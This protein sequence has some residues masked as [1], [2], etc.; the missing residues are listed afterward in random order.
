MTVNMGVLLGDVNADKVVNSADATV[1]RN[2]SGQNANATNFR[3][4]LNADGTIN[5]ADATIARN[6]SGQSLP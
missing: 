1:T 4:D 6:Q 5:A 2:D 3:A